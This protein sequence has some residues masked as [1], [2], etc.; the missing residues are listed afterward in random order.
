[1]VDDAPAPMTKVGRLAESRLEQKE[2]YGRDASQLKS[3][4]GRL[5]ASLHRSI[6]AVLSQPCE[7]FAMTVPTRV[8]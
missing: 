4:E 5:T 7:G 1:M 3:V 8:L 6:L 2:D